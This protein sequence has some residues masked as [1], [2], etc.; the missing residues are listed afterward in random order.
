MNKAATAI[1]AIL[2]TLAPVAAHA[3]DPRC[4]YYAPGEELV[5]IGDAN[6]TADG[7][8]TF[9]WRV[10]CDLEAMRP[11]WTIGARRDGSTYRNLNWQ[12]CQ[13]DVWVAGQWVRAD[14]AEVLGRRIKEGH[15]FIFDNKSELPL[16]EMTDGVIASFVGENELSVFECK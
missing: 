2:A 4:E 9:R 3:S 14:E 12:P 13:A 10:S 11:K 8:G 15:Y 1:T 6:G 7:D 5:I 16:F